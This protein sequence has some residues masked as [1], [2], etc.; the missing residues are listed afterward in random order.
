MVFVWDCTDAET[1]H[2]AL[3]FDIDGVISD[4]PDVVKQETRNS[5]S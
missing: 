1:V 4:V 3:A 2:K 5:G